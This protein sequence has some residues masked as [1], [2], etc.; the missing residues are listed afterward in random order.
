MRYISN[1]IIEVRS[2]SRN[3][4]LF[5][6]A[7]IFYQIGTGLF[8]LLYNLY[9]QGLGYGDT[10]NGRVVSIQS[11]A[12]AL[13]FVPIGLIG[14]RASCKLLL[15]V[16]SLFSGLLFL[17]RSFMGSESCLVALSVL[18]GLFASIF[19]VLAIPY[20]A[21]NINKAQRLRMFSFFSSVVLASQVFGSMG[22]G[23]LADLLQAAGITRLASL[24]TVLFLGSIATLA[25]VIP[26]LFITESSKSS[27]QVLPKDGNKVP[28]QPDPES[29][30]E[31]LAESRS[32]KPDNKTASAAKDYMFISRVLMAQLLI[33]LG[34]G[35]VVPYLN[36]Y[37]TNRFS[38]SLSAM[39]ILI[40]LGQ[41]MTIFS[42]LIGPSLAAKVGPV[43]AVVIFQLLSLPFLMLTGF[44][45]LLVVASVSFLFRQALMNAANPIQSSIMIDRVSDRRRGV[46]NSLMQTAFMLGWATMG[47]VQSYF[48][49]TYGTYWGYALTFSITGLLYVIASL[50][51]FFMFR[52]NTVKTVK[53][54]V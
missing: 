52:E 3:I 39:S 33:G 1:M 24:Q 11:L 9:I 19:Q 49:T 28:W 8:S 44:T 29:S 20:L 37:F 41:V 36:L 22:G 45:N 40:S 14:D 26:L 15:I 51:Y 50:M 53:A 42:M 21:E 10:M 18:V 16:G 5:F 13:M 34:S 43:K 12:T 35:L 6:L 25:A 47:P 27:I 7:N 38:V 48:V 17:G 54:A 32:G 46:A 31:L 4:R 23:V 2:W 30:E